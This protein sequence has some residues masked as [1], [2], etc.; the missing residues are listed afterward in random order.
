MLQHGASAIRKAHLQAVVQSRTLVHLHQSQDSE[1]QQAS[2]SGLYRASAR[3]LV[4]I[5]K[6][7]KSA[8]QQSGRLPRTWATLDSVT[9]PGASTCDLSLWRERQNAGGAAQVRQEH[10]LQHQK[11]F[12]L[13]MA[14][15]TL[16]LPR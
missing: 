1:S 12:A 6:W 13:G 9:Y 15:S 16:N 14:N 2:C 4:Q 11:R 7:S 3:P 8:T 10:G 5:E